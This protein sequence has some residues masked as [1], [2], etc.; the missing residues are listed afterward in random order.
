[1]STTNG[2]PPAPPSQSHNGPFMHFCEV[3][4]EFGP[5]GTTVGGRQAW[6]CREHDPADGRGWPGLMERQRRQG[7]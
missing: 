4:K 2:T 5:Y 7:H 6:Y 3:C 1:M